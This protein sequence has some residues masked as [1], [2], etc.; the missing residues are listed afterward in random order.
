MEGKKSIIN[1]YCKIKSGKR[2]G[3][4]ENRKKESEEKKEIEIAGGKKYKKEAGGDGAA[5][6]QKKMGKIDGREEAG[7]KDAERRTATGND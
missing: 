7:L 4:K 5:E 1:R 2:R 3:K 6:K